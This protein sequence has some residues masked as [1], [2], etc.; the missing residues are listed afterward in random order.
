MSKKHFQA[1][2]AMMQVL[3]PWGAGSI[4]GPERIQWMHTRDALASTLAGF[5]PK[6]DRG[7]F[8][9]ACEPGANVRV[10]S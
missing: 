3:H 10:R 2:A 6:F 4:N 5:N 1:F 7:R 9:R 8:E